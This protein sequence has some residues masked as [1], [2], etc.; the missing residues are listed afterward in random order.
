MVP[1]DHNFF[2]PMAPRGAYSYSGTFT[3]VA[4]TSGG[5]TGIAQ[6]LLTP[7]ANS[8]SGIGTVC[9]SGISTTATPCKANFTGGPDSRCGEQHS[10]SNSQ[11]H[12]VRLVWICRGLVEGD[13]EAD[14]D[15]RA[16]L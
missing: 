11:C 12:L 6:M 10:Q 7:M 13:L 14:S 16:A 3:D 15:P 8:L 9:A 4:N 1:A 2:Q 5:N